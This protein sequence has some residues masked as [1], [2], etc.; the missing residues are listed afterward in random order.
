MASVH[1]KDR[2]RVKG[3]SYVPTGFGI[4]G[5]GELYLST[6][7]EIEAGPDAQ[8]RLLLRPA[9]D[10]TKCLVCSVCGNAFERTLRNIKK[11]KQPR[12]ICC[13]RACGGTLG[14]PRKTSKRN[15]DDV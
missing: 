8:L 11:R 9:K 13:S 12:T 7:T 1:V 6:P 10:P 3:V 4:P 2:Y 5:K 15:N 14:G